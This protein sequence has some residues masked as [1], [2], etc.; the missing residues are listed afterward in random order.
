[1]TA[2]VGA[3]RGAAIVAAVWMLGTCG[4][5]EAQQRTADVRTRNGQVWQL[6]DPTLHVLFTV[7]PK[8][9]EGE[10]GLPTPPG[11]G[12]QATPGSAGGSMISPAG[13]GPQPQVSG[14]VQS[15]KKALASGPEPL[16]A[17]RTSDVLTIVKNETEILV[18]LASIA[19]L[20]IS[21]IDVPNSTLPPYVAAAHARYSAA[22]ALTDGSVLEG[23]YMNPGTMMLRGTAPAGRVEIPLEEVESLRFVP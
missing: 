2:R 10:Q 17:Q 23:D 22:I 8:P 5:A 15:L 4:V 16:R 13:G 14:S 6:V 3:T 11:A 19:V 9:A 18:P 12:P 20:A 7:I 1:M 21:R